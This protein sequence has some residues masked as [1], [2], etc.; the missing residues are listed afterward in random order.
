[1]NSDVETTGRLDEFLA[2]LKG[3]E[4]LLHD[5]IATEYSGWL[6]VGHTSRLPIKLGSWPT[7]ALKRR[8]LGERHHSR[9]TRKLL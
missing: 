9:L 5:R 2:V 7:A 6:E 4:D 3:S 1:M 8:N